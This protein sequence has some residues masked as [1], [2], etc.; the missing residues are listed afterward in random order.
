MRKVFLSILCFFT[1]CFGLLFACFNDDPS[2]HLGN[3]RTFI[4]GAGT[5]TAPGY[6]IWEGE[7]VSGFRP[8]LTLLAS[9]PFTLNI[10]FPG[11]VNN[12][13]TPDT[14]IVRAILFYYSQKD[15]WIALKDIRNPVFQIVSDLPLPV[16]GRHC[17]PSNLGYA[18]MKPIPVVIYFET[19]NNASFDLAQFL[20][21]R[22]SLDAAN[23]LK[24]PIIAL[25]ANNNRIAH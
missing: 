15:G 14:Q 5:V 9:F 21:R 18:R 11:F 8:D 6:S 2:S 24:A 17:I 1:F 23:E 10:A 16:F 19:K 20:A 22:K 7:S 25:I 13:G 4:E 12:D 3:F